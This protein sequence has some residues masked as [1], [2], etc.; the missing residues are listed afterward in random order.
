MQ[1][2]LNNDDN[3]RIPECGPTGIR[4]SDVEFLGYC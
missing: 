3:T 4:K 1:E 2:L